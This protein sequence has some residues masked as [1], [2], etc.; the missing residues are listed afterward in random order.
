MSK[1]IELSRSGRTIFRKAEHEKPRR[2]YLRSYLLHLFPRSILPF[3]FSSFSPVLKHEILHLTQYMY[4]N[5]FVARVV[6]HSARGVGSSSLL[7]DPIPKFRFLAEVFLSRDPCFAPAA[8][9]F[10][11]KR[12]FNRGERGNFRGL[13]REKCYSRENSNIAFWSKTEFWFRALWN[14]VTVLT[15][16]RGELISGIKRNCERSLRESK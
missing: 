12:T 4:A 2:F 15:D 9:C 6:S 1:S 14:V 5:S 10:A 13:S 7:D 11:Q 16:V 8:F 3:S